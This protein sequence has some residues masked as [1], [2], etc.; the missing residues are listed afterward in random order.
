MAL[1]IG[2]EQGEEAGMDLAGAFEQGRGHGRAEWL[3]GRDGRE[4]AQLTQGDFVQLQIGR[5]AVADAASRFEQVFGGILVDLAG[6]KA[7]AED[8]DGENG[9]Q[10]K[11]QQTPNHQRFEGGQRPSMDGE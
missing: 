1:G 8:D 10:G 3:A 5:Q 9:K 7:A 2:D 4:G 11:G 6:E